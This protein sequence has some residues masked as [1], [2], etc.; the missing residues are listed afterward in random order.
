MQQVD[1]RAG[2]TEKLARFV[3][4]TSY[5]ALSAEV[6]AAAKVGIL[7]G[8]ANMLAGATQPLA[9]IIGAY[10]KQLGGNPQ[11]AVI[12][13][14]FRT[15]APS[16]AFANGVFLHCLDFEI[17]GQPVAHGTSNILPPAL[18]LGEMSGASGARLIEAYV[19]GWEINARLR[20]AS[21]RCDTR[22]YHPPGLLGPL[23]AAAA[24][25]KMLG[26]DT[27]GVRMALGIAASHTGGLTANTGTMV[28]STHPGAA[29][30]QGVESALLAQA[31]FL[32]RDGILEVRQGFVDTLLG[33]GFDWDEL[34]RGLGKN[35]QLVDPGFNIKRYPAQIFMQWAIE[36]ALTVR[37]RHEFRP[38]DITYVELE[39]PGSHVRSGQDV[40]ASGLDGKFD[41]A[42]CGAVAIADGRVDIDSF[43]DAMR[44]SPRV[45][46][47]L[48]KVRIK[49]NPD[50][51]RNPP[52]TWAV[53]RVGLRDGR[54]LSETCRHYR[55]SIA[56][57]M[58]RGE[59][60]V[61]LRDCARRSL[62]SADIE[63]VIGMAEALE[64]LPDLRPL[65]L[66]LG[67]RSVK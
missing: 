25:A 56:N 55:G 41:F 7:D 66:V 22:G 16:A 18:A 5:N 63:R 1:S 51:P 20:K 67:H 50:I 4:E 38:E 31:G 32:S 39:V 47:I 17:Q 61:K 33:T 52:D 34:T 30:R 46:S 6:V 26:L 37:L 10:L 23:A 11:C 19:I 24:S 14:D 9:A 44:F 53:A 40:A 45:E 8:I 13:Q 64:S 35:Y 65:M 3:T 36:A 2:A 43:S 62:E 29:A 57:P 60:L 59:R 28:K 49:A 27:A 58:D 54:V 12:G 15:N 42:Y 48:Q 21:V